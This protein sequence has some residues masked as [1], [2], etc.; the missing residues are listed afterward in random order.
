MVT[1]PIGDGNTIRVEVW[2]TT[3]FMD[4]K[5]FHVWVQRVIDRITDGGLLRTDEAE[6]ITLREDFKEILKEGKKR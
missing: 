5:E 1:E 3:S 6:F 2:K 4:T